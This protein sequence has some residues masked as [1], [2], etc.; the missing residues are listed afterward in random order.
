MLVE[1]SSTRAHVEMFQS[2]F[3]VGSVANMYIYHVDLY[4]GHSFW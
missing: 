1:H 2:T 4:Q 3:V